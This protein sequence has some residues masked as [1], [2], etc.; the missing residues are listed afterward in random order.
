[1]TQNSVA[2]GKR[3]KEVREARKATDPRFSLR[4]FADAVGLSP[5]F[6]SRLEHG[7]GVLPSPANLERIAEVLEIEAK[8]LF[9]LAQRVEPQVKDLLLEQPAWADFL[10]TARSRGWDADA[11]KQFVEDHYTEPDTDA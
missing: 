1:M 2:V 6:I 11:V 5:T 7:T 4:R 8:E 10:R 3:I 9:E